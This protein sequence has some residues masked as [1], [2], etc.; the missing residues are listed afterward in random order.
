MLTSDRAMEIALRAHHGQVNKHNGEPYILH[1]MRVAR[2]VR[3]KYN[4]PDFT[5]VAWLHDVVEDTDTTLEYLFKVFWDEPQI[6]QAVSRLTKTRGQS[7][8]EYYRNILGNKLAVAVK[9]EDIHDNFRRNHLIEDEGTRLR[10]AAKYS[11]GMDIL[12]GVRATHDC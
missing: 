2:S 3:D 10:M 12:G 11:L 8:D 9:L 4:D 6:P 1:V 7:N 5:A